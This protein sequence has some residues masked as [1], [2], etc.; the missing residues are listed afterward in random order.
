MTPESK[1]LNDYLVADPVVNWKEKMV[2]DKANELSKGLSDTFTKAQYLFEWVRDNIPHSKDI[3]SDIVTC[4]ASEVLKEGTGICAAKSHLLA[5]LCRAVKIPAGFCYQKLKQDPPFTGFVLHSFNGIYISELQKW[6]I[7]DA[8]GNTG[9]I[10]AQFDINQKG[11]A[12]PTHSDEG[13]ILYDPI[14]VSP[15][16]EYIETLNRYKSRK[17]MWAFLPSELPH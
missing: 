5:A 13:E 10:N 16:P 9:D 3:D 11:L 2:L 15:A 8:R 6:I 1:Y 7:V 4:S 12:F 14:F 17:E